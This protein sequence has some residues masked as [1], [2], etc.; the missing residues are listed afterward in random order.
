MLLTRIKMKS[1][2]TLPRGKK[3]RNTKTETE[4]EVFGGERLPN[5]CCPQIE[6]AFRPKLTG[7]SE[8]RFAA[9]SHP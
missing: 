8:K 4:S 6:A 3:F 7:S 5:Q 2:C 1:E 9:R